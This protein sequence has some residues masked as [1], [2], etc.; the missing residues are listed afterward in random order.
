MNLN[1]LLVDDEQPIL[2]NLTEF[3]SWETLGIE[4]AGTARTGSEALELVAH[5]DPDLILCDIRMPIMDGLTFIKQYRDQGG[6]GEILLLTG[7]QEFEY[8]RLALQQGVKEYICKPIDYIELEQ[9]IGQL[10]ENIQARKMK[11]QEGSQQQEQMSNWIRRKWLLELLLGESE[12]P[13]PCVPQSGTDEEKSLYTLIL[14]DAQDYF[15]RAMFWSDQ[16]R[17]I[18]HENVRE[19]LEK[20]LA[21]LVPPGIVIQT[22]EGEWCIVIE[23]RSL[24]DKIRRDTIQERMSELKQT[25]EEE[26]GMHV[27]LYSE[28]EEVVFSLLAEQYLKAQQA[29]ML[30][31]QPEHLTLRKDLSIEEDDWMSR[32][33]SDRLTL[34]IRHQ[35]KNEIL[36]ILQQLYN[37]IC[38]NSNGLSGKAVKYFHYVVVH[39]LREM[40]EMRVL[41]P[42]AEEKIWN[43][44]LQPLTLREFYELALTLAEACGEEQPRRS[45]GSLVSSAKDYIASRLDQDLGIE[46]MADQLNI[47]PS[48]F[49]QL[50]KSHFGVTFVEYITKERMETAKKLLASTDRSIAS[51]GASVGYRERRY[52]SKVFHKHYGMKPSEYREMMVANAEMPTLIN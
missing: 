2:D 6:N 19:A 13:N 31:E 28:G 5:Y 52:F 14:L 15:R 3:I 46:E 42:E 1:V 12:S 26:A 18:W 10:A 40:H 25:F 47:S 17:K 27:R 43:V 32:A 21:S 50:F 7:Y 39:M 20:K 29:V 22:R 37:V 36:N 45:A 24:F 44:M 9:T 48:Y 8:A 35:N 41:K 51:I 34:G 33:W 4:I 49:C 23:H 30:V 11:E 16:E 38:Q